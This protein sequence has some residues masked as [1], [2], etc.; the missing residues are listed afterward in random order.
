MPIPE[1]E[2]RIVWSK[3]G[4]SCAICR[5]RVLVPSASGLGTHLVG[6]VAHIVAEQGDGP[7]GVSPMSLAERNADPNLLLLCF[8]HHKI[9]DD[10]LATY[11]VERLH[12]IR[13][14]HLEWVDSRLRDEK[15]WATKFHGFYYLNVPRLNILAA[16]AGASLDLSE[17]SDLHSLH[18]LSWELNRLMSG[19]KN[20]LKSIEL[21]AVDLD[22]ALSYGEHARGV[23]VSF[24][25]D[26]RTKNIQ[27][28]E[29]PQGY[30]RRLT[31]NLKQDPHIYADVQELRVVMPI[32]LRWVTTTTAFVHFRPSGGTGKFAGLGIVNSVDL[33][34]KQVRVS[35]LVIGIPTTPFLD[36]L[37][38]N[39]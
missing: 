25:R 22:V 10:D 18:E 28:P 29:S 37:Y 23:V 5:E 12:K 13:Q 32:D 14:D 15:P 20:L 8:D 24:D 33:V 9:I 35:P 4:G 30:E 2:R 11:T 39:T 36:A 3:A 7:R 16:T 31:G 27:L 34:T 21:K 17:F 26:F 1:R 19:F 38:G 6:E